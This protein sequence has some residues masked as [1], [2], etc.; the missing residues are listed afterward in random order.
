MFLE[1]L[2]QATRISSSKAFSK[3]FRLQVEQEGM[4][5]PFNRSKGHLDYFLL[6]NWAIFKI[7]YAME[8][9]SKIET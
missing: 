8:C 2:W 6:K 5:R 1:S 3:G 7:N 4:I 9:Q